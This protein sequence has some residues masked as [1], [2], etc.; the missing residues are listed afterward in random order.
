[1]SKPF[2]SLRK[3]NEKVFYSITLKDKETCKKLQHKQNLQ[4][5]IAKTILNNDKATGVQLAILH[6]NIDWFNMSDCNFTEQEY[7]D[8]DYEITAYDL[9]VDGNGK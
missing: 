5:R 1:M 9:C 4:G 2:T 7:S 6:S 3:K 8:E